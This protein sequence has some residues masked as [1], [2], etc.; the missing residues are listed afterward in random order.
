MRI[1]KVKDNIVITIPYWSK[2][3]NPYME[4][5]D[6]GQYKTL[7]GLITNDEFGNE[8]IGFSLVID[9]GYKGKPDQ[10]TD[11]MIHWWEGTKEDFIK[12]C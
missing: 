8:E 2:R 1:K 4:G 5:E 9:M 6:C 10:E 12:L 7:M 11:I 3:H